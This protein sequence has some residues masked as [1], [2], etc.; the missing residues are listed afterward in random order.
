MVD[1][2][3]PTVLAS[4]DAI[5]K[6]ISHVAIG[7]YIW[8]AVSSV[9]FEWSL[10]TRKRAFKW[11]MLLYFYCKWM[12][13]ASF[14]GMLIAL[15]VHSAINCQ[16]L[17]NFNQFA[18]NSALGA[19]STLL[20]LRSIA[21]WQRNRWIIIFFLV[22]G[23]GLWGVQ[24]HG[25][26]TV[27]ASWDPLLATC[28]VESVTGIY[29]TLVYLYT[30]FTDLSVLIVTLAGLSWSP[31]RSGLWRMLWD[32]GISF[33][34]VA[35]IANLIPAVMLLVNLNPVINIMFSIPAIA[36]TATC[37]CR[38]FVGL[39]EYARRGDEM[40]AALATN[41][42]INGG[43]SHRIQGPTKAPKGST[44]QF[45]RGMGSNIEPG[46]T[47]TIDAIMRSN[48]WGP[49]GQ[50]YIRY[51]ERD[52]SLDDIASVKERGS[53]DTLSFSP[54][55]NSPAAML[56]AEPIRR[57]SVQMSTRD[58][59]RRPSLPVI[60]PDSSRRPSAVEID[61]SNLRHRGRGDD[62]V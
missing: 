34:I 36:A 46:P 28:N 60:S 31:G 43:W 13:V 33:F 30:M 55:D 62:A 42:S 22:V 54:L 24:M 61:L 45:T 37:A 14:V 4:C 6:S 19:S 25:V 32:Q 15:N 58:P 38:C 21:I 9:G 59:N 44:V 16:A 56:P 20:M 53:D 35:F 17:Y 41:H 18:G 7:A 3:S 8:E 1:W 50:R 48:A 51:S 11:P 49:P 10:I 40:S 5:F 39:S 29:L 26:T 27:R 2:N 47:D 23:C 12:L 52:I 57:P